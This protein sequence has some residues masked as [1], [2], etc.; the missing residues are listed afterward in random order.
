MTSPALLGPS[1]VGAEEFRAAMAALAAP[2]C[3]I[4]C[5]DR[6]G[7]TRGLT[8]SAVCALSLDP[9]LLLV[10]V[11]RRSST[12]DALVAAPAF[13]VNLLGPGDEELARRC[14][15]PA[16]TRFAG[17][18]TVPGPAPGLAVAALRLTCR[19][20]GLRDGGDHTILMGEVVAADGDPGRAGGLVWHQRGFAH[21]RPADRG[22]HT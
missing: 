1:A 16:A 2:V 7:G 9:P 19:N 12:H 21:A 17:V 20:H 4:T 14:A 11:D 5:Y 6:D 22:P 15:G 10:A 8:A 3:V 18:P 13:A